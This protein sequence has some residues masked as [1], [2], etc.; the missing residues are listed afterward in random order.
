[1]KSF[2]EKMQEIEKLS[3]EKREKKIKEVQDICKDFCGNCP[4]YQNTGEDRLGFC[5]TGKSDKIEEERGCLCG[6]CPV[7]EKMSLRW[8]YYC[9]RGSAQ[10]QS[11][12]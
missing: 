4:T 7:T 12:E 9:T 8:G 3:P 10:K 1:M 2:E 11:R 6:S 5:A